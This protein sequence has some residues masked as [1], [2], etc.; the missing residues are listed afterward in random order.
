MV[1]DLGSTLP[2][3]RWTEAWGG[4]GERVEAGNGEVQKPVVEMGKV[5]KGLGQPQ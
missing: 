4:E 3:D 2:R 1:I 5:E